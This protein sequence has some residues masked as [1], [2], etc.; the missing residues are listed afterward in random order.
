VTAVCFFM[1]HASACFS[2]R[3]FPVKKQYPSVQCPA[4]LKVYLQM[5]SQ[6]GHVES[7]LI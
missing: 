2:M 3:H 1:I 7:H 5:D 4:T 6:S